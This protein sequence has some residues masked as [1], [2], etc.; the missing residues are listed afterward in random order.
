MNLC[1]KITNILDLYY[2]NKT[3][4]IGR[5]CNA[6]ELFLFMLTA[7]TGSVEH[8]SYYSVKLAYEHILERTS[9]SMTHGPFGGVKG[10]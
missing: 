9:H 6:N 7:V 3:K 1:K 10:L 8:G 4:I 2:G 5:K